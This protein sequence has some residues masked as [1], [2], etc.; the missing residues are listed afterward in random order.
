MLLGADSVNRLLHFA[1]TTIATFNSVGGRRQQR[2]IEEDQGF[3]Q[4]GREQLAEGLA[5]FA[6]PPHAPSQPGQFGQGRVRAATTVEEAVNLVHAVMTRLDPQFADKHEKKKSVLPKIE[7]LQQ[8]MDELQFK[9]Y[10]EQKRSL[11]ICLQAPDA[12]GKDG[13]VRHVIGSMNPQGCRVV[14][15]K[16]PTPEEAAHDYLWRIE[17]QTPK[18]GEVVIFN[19]SH[20][21]DVLIVRVHELVPKKVWS[22]RYEQ[23]NDF[24]RMLDADA[25]DVLQADATRCLGP[26]GF[27]Q[28]AALAFAHHLPLSAHC[29]PSLHAPLLCAAPAG[30]HC[31]YFHD[32][33]R[34]EG[35]YL[36]GAPAPDQGVLRPDRARP[37]FGLAP[38]RAELER[39][40][41]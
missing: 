6:K 15:F 17:H 4:I 16:Q 3:F 37:G 2:V 21:E 32:H 14:S 36:E 13:V 20:Y 19:R 10:A 23:I 1:V 7:N 31:E 34:I 26:T 22:K 40:A 41:V 12:G 24:E 27:L 11:L 39:F 5:D 33:A 25:V 35:S 18:R 30:V 28:A 29:A 8:R 38:K 9:L